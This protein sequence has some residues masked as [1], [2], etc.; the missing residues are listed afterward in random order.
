MGHHTSSCSYKLTESDRVLY[1]WSVA[2]IIPS[3][4]AYYPVLAMF[5][6]YVLWIYVHATASQQ[7]IIDS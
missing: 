6:R 3:S 2:A 7:V 5:I 4:F 1:D